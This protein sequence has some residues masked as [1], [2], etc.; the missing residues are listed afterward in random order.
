MAA[1]KRTSNTSSRTSRELAV[2]LFNLAWLLPRTIGSEDK[3]TDPLPRSEL[4]VMRLLGRRPGTTVNDVAR[5]LGLQPSNASATI[6]SLVS[7][8]LVERRDDPSDG[9]QVLLH[10]TPAAQESREH[11]ERRWG[12]E[13]ATLLDQLS[14]DERSRLLASAPVLATLAERLSERAR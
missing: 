14:A 2:S 3:Q 8:G 9:R 12:H 10:L 1:A 11:R 4:E 7:R 6:G 13:L 5:E